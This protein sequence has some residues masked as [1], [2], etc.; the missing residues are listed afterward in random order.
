MY[1]TKYTNNLCNFLCEQLLSTVRHPFILLLKKTV[2]ILQ[3]NLHL[4]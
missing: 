1:T 4:I 2:Y 3:V